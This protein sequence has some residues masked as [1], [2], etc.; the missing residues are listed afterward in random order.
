MEGTRESCA[1]GAP[2]EAAAAPCGVLG[3]RSCRLAAARDTNARWKLY[4]FQWKI[5]PHSCT[6]GTELHMPPALPPWMRMWPS[7]RVHAL[8]PPW[9]GV[10]GRTAAV[11]GVAGQPRRHERRR[12]A[13][14]AVAAGM[15]AAARQHRLAARAGRAAPAAAAGGL[16]PPRPHR[17]HLFLQ[18]V[19][20]HPAGDSRLVRSWAGGKKNGCL[21]LPSSNRQ[22]DHPS[23]HAAGLTARHSHR[24]PV[25]SFLQG[26]QPLHIGPTGSGW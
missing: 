19:A 25:G 15:T 22:Q 21:G 2:T 3:R 20:P 9:Q 18:P 16:L 12:S 24:F 17:V 10:C 5:D 8:A 11:R 4:V 1:L 26:D 14:A 7:P 13:L 23:S 6:P